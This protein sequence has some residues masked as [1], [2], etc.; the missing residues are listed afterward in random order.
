MIFVAGVAA[1][2]WVY[3]FVL[4]LVGDGTARIAGAVLAG[5]SVVALG[6]VAMPG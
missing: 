2:S 6:L 3:G 4:A 1:V 5:A